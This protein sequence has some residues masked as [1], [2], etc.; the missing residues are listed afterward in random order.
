MRTQKNLFEPGLN[1]MMNWLHLNNTDSRVVYVRQY[2]RT[3][4]DWNTTEVIKVSEAT[5]KTL[6]KKK[7]NFIQ[8]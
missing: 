4:F 7:I 1:I 2:K 3:L 5:K 6:E 8:R